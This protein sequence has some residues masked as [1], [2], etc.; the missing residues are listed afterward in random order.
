MMNKKITILILCLAVMTVISGCGKK[1]IKTVVDDNNKQRVEKVATTTKK[2]NGN[3]WKV[4]RNKVSG[5][6]LRYPNSWNCRES[7]DKIMIDS[8]VTCLDKKGS[9]D[10]HINVSKAKKTDDPVK[11][12]KKIRGDS[13]LDTPTPDKLNYKIA[14]A[15]GVRLSYQESVYGN[16]P[17]W[18]GIT[19]VFIKNYKVFHIYIHV[20][21][22]G[23][24]K[25]NIEKILQSL[26]VE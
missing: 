8:M 18:E 2:I 6:E 14:G 25:D 19:I 16:P 11:Y 15:E 26:K 3:D 12:L 22:D 13:I 17:F 24:Q 5:Y 7:T 4:Y 20:D 1:E 9:A 10:M 21:D 23:M